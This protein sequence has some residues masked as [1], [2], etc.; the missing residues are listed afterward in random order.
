M[1]RDTDKI[2]I[3]SAHRDGTRGEIVISGVTPREAFA[4]V[5]RGDVGAYTEQERVAIARTVTRTPTGY[6]FVDT[7]GTIVWIGKAR[8][9][10]KAH[11]SWSICIKGGL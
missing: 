7:D 1:Q 2:F 4:A 8:P 9:E 5:M 6:S 11:F 10:E 3:R